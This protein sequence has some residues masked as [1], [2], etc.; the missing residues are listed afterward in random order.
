MKFETHIPAWAGVG[1]KVI[2]VFDEVV[3]SGSAKGVRTRVLYLDKKGNEKLMTKW[4]NW[5]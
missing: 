4:I 2:K 3:T 1:C 5:G